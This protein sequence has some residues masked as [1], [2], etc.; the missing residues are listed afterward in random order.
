M[1]KSMV[2]WDVEDRKLLAP[3]Y[4]KCDN[5]DALPRCLKFREARLDAFL[6]LRQQGKSALLKYI[7]TNTFKKVREQPS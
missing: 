7:F 4:I 5:Y 1:M 2:E 6:D 3:N